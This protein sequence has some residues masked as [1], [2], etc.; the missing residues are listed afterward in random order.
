M[1]RVCAG[2]HLLDDC[3]KSHLSQLHARQAQ[4]DFVIDCHY[5]D[6]PVRGAEFIRDEEMDLLVFTVANPAEFSLHAEIIRSV[7]F[8][9]YAGTRFRAQQGASVDELSRLP[10]ILPMEGS[11]ACA[12]VETALLSTGIVCRNVLARAQ[13][14]SVLKDMAKQGEGVVA[15]F[16]TMIKPEDEAKLIK[17][18]VELPTM[19]R[20]LFRANGVT[21]AA[22]KSAESFLRNALTG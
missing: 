14:A 15:L 2:G 6:S 8:G 12:M 16:D 18:D 17:L 7:S 19:Y 21:D 5:V 22:I 4:T 9:L 11:E 3:I 1:V 20:T 10:F 13:F